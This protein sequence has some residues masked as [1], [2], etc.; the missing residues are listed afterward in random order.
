[1]SYDHLIAIASI[2]ATVFVGIASVW[3]NHFLTSRKKN[4]KEPYE[5]VEKIVGDRD[6]STTHDLLLETQFQSLYKL[7]TEASAIRYLLSKKHPTKKVRQYISGFKHLDHVRYK[8]GNIKE[9]KLNKHTSKKWI[10]N[11]QYYGGMTLYWVLFFVGTLPIVIFANYIKLFFKSAGFIVL[12]PTLGW[13]GLFIF[14]AVVSLK[15]AVNL[16]GA[17][18]LV[19]S[20]KPK[21]P[22][23][24]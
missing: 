24:A 8:N 12:L 2:I 1:M 23:P 22:D 20:L 11:T 3:L 10:Y 19:E 6:I 15:A 17:K 21:Q 7:N 14:F 16:G 5:M 9:L 13:M 18:E 4:S